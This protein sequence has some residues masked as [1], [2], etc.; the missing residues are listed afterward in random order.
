MRIGIMCHSSMGGSSSIAIGLALELAR[1]QHT[2]HL[3]A[4]SQP[5][6]PWGPMDGVIL[7]CLQAS[8]SQPDTEAALYI[9]WTEDEIQEMA[10]LIVDVARSETLDVL[11]FHY[12][13][14]FAYIAEIVKDTLGSTSPA[15]VGTLHGTD[16][17]LHSQHSVH[18]M[19]L[20][21]SLQRIDWLTTVSHHHAQLAR[22]NFELVKTPEV[23]Y[24]FVDLVRFRPNLD[25][26]PS[27][28]RGVTPVIAHASN[29]RPV[30]NTPLLARIFADIT[31]R[32][33]AELWLV[34]DGPDRGMVERI[35]LENNVRQFARFW[36]A[37]RNI[38]PMLRQAD[39]LLMTSSHE[40]FCLAAME[41]MACG[42]PVLVPRVGGLP[43]IV[44]NGE[45]GLLFE[46]DDFDDVV[47]KAIV[48][49]SNPHQLSLMGRAARRQAS[50]FSLKII[51]N[52]Y[53]R[54]YDRLLANRASPVFVSG[55]SIARC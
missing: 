27:L 42:I 34:G 53:T 28:D 44:V 55:V 52:T 4:R 43:E 33:R 8:D 22:V 12:A 48:L 40:S 6:I 21:A 11:H 26:R 5:F 50:N 41:A 17:S 51:C 14:P 54:L 10:D 45:T 36:G 23:I 35:L 30:K 20:Q 24:N 19:S 47:E 13:I 25:P 49:L 32:I 15:L 16:V 2:V 18:G 29:F 9:D 38:A 3:F 39:L 46:L 7:H 37:Q 31:I 1:Q